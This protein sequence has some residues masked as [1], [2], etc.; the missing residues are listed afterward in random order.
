FYFQTTPP[1]CGG[2]VCVNPGFAWNHGNVQ[3]E[4]GNTWVG[5]VG[6]GVKNLGVDSGTWTDHT[7]VRPTI[8]ELLGL[9]DSYRDDGRVLVEALDSRA[10]VQSLRAH[11]ET[12]LRLGSAYE[13]VNAPFGSFAA[14]TLAA[15]TRALKSADEGV[16]SSLESRIADLTAQRD[17][18]ALRISIALNDAAAGS[19]LDEQL[20]KRWIAEADQLLAEAR[21]LAG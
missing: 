11:R 3:E 12:L 15:S 2:D 21:A 6:P 19:P 7:N 4:I 10:V 16:Y 13:Q 14:D 17:A 18:L 1:S 8:N 9:R 20:A 5:F